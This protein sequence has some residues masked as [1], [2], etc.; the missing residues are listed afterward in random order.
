MGRQADE[1][2][3]RPVPMVS[4]YYVGVH[5]LDVNV[6]L[7]VIVVLLNNVSQDQR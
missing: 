5:F 2:S 4:R 6:Q 1:I 3:I 7:L